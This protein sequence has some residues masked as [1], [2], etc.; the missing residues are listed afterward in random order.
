MTKKYQA[1]REERLLYTIGTSSLVIT[2]VLCYLFSF[3]D[4]NWIALFW[5]FFAITLMSYVIAANITI[6]RVDAEYENER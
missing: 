1:D 3:V 5:V 6:K 2:I 4:Y